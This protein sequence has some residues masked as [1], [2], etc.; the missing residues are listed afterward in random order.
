V[1]SDPD[2][3]PSD[4]GGPGDA[5]RCYAAALRILQLR[6]NSA[7]ELRRKLRRKAF[8]DETI[9]TT[10]ERLS[11]ERWLD[12][13]RFAAAVVRTQVRKRHGRLRIERE[14][15]A[16]G[17]S[18]GAI[19]RAIDDHVDAEEERAAA[20]AAGTKKLASLLRRHGPEFAAMPEARQKV[21]AF[22]QGRGYETTLII[23]VVRE[24]LP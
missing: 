16:A 2:E 19:A 17:V 18:Q 11:R 14:L 13:D 10:L 20:L 3:G 1:A 9:A 12:D 23:D 24:L 22:L 7:V 6:W 15:G 21:S 8:D 4:S 5:E